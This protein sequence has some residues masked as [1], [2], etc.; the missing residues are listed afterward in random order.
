[1]RAD[2]CIHNGPIVTEGGV[3]LGAVI[4]TEGKIAA[5]LSDE[6]LK[7]DFPD[8][9]ETIDLEGRVL[10]PGLVDEHVHLSQVGQNY[11]GYQTGTRAAAAGGVTTVLDMPLDDSPPT[12]DL[13][14]LEEK[15]RLAD[16]KAV[17]DYAHWGGLV[18]ANESNL[19]VMHRAGVVGFKGF[20]AKGGDFPMIGDDVL[21]AGLR[22]S[23]RLNTVIGIH[24]E[25]GSVIAKLESELR[26]ADRRDRR[27]WT[28]ARP[29][30]VELEAIERAIYWTGVTGGHLVVVHTSIAEGVAAAS[31]ARLR[32]IDAKIEVCPHHLVFSDEDHL[33]KGA[34]LKVSPPLRSK[35]QV[36]AMWDCVLRGE[37]HSVASD[38]S[39]F[40]PERYVSGEDDV[41][42][43][44]GIAGIQTTLP[45]MITEGVHSRGLKWDDLARM[46]S[47]NPAKIFGLYPKK[48][49]LLPGADADFVIVDPEQKWQLQE[50]DLLNRWPS[51]SPYIGRR[52][53][54]K[55]E[56]TIVRGM[57]VYADGNILVEPGY[58]R[59]VMARRAGLALRS[60]DSG[61]DG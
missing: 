53:H 14:R 32:G 40:L 1:M 34:Y 18:D 60:S 52:F 58:G 55:V 7:T 41:W 30:F 5:L 21:F 22:S 37:V 42:L 59:L 19:E 17:V 27:A 25:N 24:A 33:A 26:E 48:G 6:D 57:T 31:R 43:G 36:E 15:R 47:T 9:V 28:E 20:L 4:V 11:E 61:E 3:L 38:H 8:T 16:G 35:A 10:L 44:G 13:T 2:L 49:S 39:P 46:T 54:G 56:R 50:K 23:R 12:T 45:T 29:E 51:I